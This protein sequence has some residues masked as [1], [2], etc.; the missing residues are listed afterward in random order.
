MYLLLSGFGN[1]TVCF[2]KGADV[3]GL[4]SPEVAVDRPVEGEL[5]G[6]LIE[7]S[8]GRCEQEQDAEG[9]VGAGLQR[10]TEDHCRL[11]RYVALCAVLA[12]VSSTSMQQQ[13]CRKADEDPM[14][15]W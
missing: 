13:Q 11:A 15:G 8:E 2:E 12:V 9:V 7:R 14:R 5:E 1:V 6:A 4:A 10:R 3:E